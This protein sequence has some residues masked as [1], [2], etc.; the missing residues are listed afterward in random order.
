[1]IECPAEAPVSPDTALSAGQVG[2]RRR[3]ARLENVSPELIPLLRGHAPPQG[4]GHDDLAAARGIAFSI[5]LG[6]LIWLS[7]AGVGYWLLHG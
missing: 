5:A 2:E 1:M 7:L 4:H 3:P 6:G